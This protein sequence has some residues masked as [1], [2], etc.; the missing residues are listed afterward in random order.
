MNDN[1]DVTVSRNEEGWRSLYQFL[2]SLLGLPAGEQKDII[3]ETLWL[4][5]HRD[6]S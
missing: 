2:E 6:N 3:R 5:K 4:L 1:K